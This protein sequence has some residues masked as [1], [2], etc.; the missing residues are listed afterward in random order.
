MR[1]PAEQELWLLALLVTASPAEGGCVDNGDT[2]PVADAETEPGP[3]C[4][5]SAP[6]ATSGGDYGVPWEEV[7]FGDVPDIKLDTGAIPSPSDP[8]GW[9]SN[10]SYT[11][12]FYRS[13]TADEMT[14]HGWSERDLL[15]TFDA[16]F[17]SDVTGGASTATLKLPLLDHGQSRPQTN[18]TF[19]EI[20]WKRRR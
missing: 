18:L 4:G 1:V 8:T 11:G 16:T 19:L 3:L 9:E 12:V 20:D 10:S 2:D 6:I 13:A 7:V 14:D 15:V 17:K 5:A